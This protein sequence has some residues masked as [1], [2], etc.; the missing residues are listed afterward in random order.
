MGEVDPFARVAA[1]S[2]A[3]PFDNAFEDG[4]FSVELN[5]EF[6]T[7]DLTLIA[8]SR[9]FDTTTGIDADF[10]RMDLLGVRAQA[11]ELDESS[12]EIRLASSGA[13]VLDWVVGAFVFDQTIAATDD[14]L[15]GVH[16]RAYGDLL[17]QAAT[18]GA[19][20]FPALEVIFGLPAGSIFANGTGTRNEFDY[21][22]NGFAVFGQGTYH[23]NDQWSITGGLRYSDEEKDFTATNSLANEPFSQVPLPP[24][25]A[26]LSAFQAFPATDPYSISFADDNISGTFNVAYNISGSTSAYVRY[27]TG[28]KSGGINLS[29]NAGRNGT[30]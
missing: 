22:A 5:H 16:G 12:F 6:D 25:L 17:T 28:F 7:T 23:I 19:L 14:L 24:S 4:G 15:L 20:S 11:Q 26:G 3:A 18:G 29:R 13:N 1:H 27:A 10:Q 8:A 21:S 2:S 30:G 9:C